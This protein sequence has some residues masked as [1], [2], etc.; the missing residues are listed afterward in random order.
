ML[1]IAL[2]FALA[3]VLASAALP[4][5]ATPPAG[6]EAGTGQLPAE[7]ILSL[8]AFATIG[9]DGKLTELEWPGKTAGEQWLAKRLDARVRTWEFVPGTLDG[10]PVPTRT[11]LSI[12]VRATPQ[13]D[14]SLELRLIDAHT[15]PSLLTRAWPRFPMH[16][17]QDGSEVVA[18]AE[19]VIAADGTAAVTSVEIDSKGNRRAIEKTVREAFADWRFAPEIV[20]GR[21]V[22]TRMT[23]PM[24]FCRERRGSDYCQKQHLRRTAAAEAAAGL[25]ALPDGMPIALDSATRLKTEI[26]DQVL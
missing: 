22:A 21:A 15:G 13:A 14:G 6:P 18:R 23:V 1:R 12:R 8:A 17:L 24:N 5:L 4:A 11:G 20:G 16:A 10:V 3:C 7:K 9:I 25:P 2:P 26:R 19:L